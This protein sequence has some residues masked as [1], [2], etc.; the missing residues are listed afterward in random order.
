MTTQY[1]RQAQLLIGAGSSLI[2][3]SQMEMEFQVQAWSMETPKTAMIRVY[4]LKPDTARRVTSEGAQVVLSAGYEGN[5]NT[6][7][8]GQLIQARIGRENGTDTYLDITAAVGDYVYNHGTLNLTVAAGV[9]VIGRLGM[10]ANA[11]G[12][13]LGTV[14][15]PANDAGLPRGRVYFGLARDHL[16][17]ECAS[18][19]A[20][21]CITDEGKLDVIASGSYKPGDIPVINA[22]TG[23]I[24]VPEQTEIGVMVRCLLN[25]NLQQNMV[26]QLD[27]AQ[28]QQ[29]A[30]PIGYFAE[31]D[32]A[33]IP[34]LSANGLYKILYVNHVGQTRG[35]DW[36]TDLI[37]YSKIV[38]PGQLQ[39]LPKVF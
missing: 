20:H 27:N 21:W 22:S 12:L 34:D 9:G 24:G 15:A 6:I 2:D 32:A 14:Q 17:K 26:V 3:L 30:Y 18:I 23:L 29:M 37:C 11:V 7:F 31:K 33:F 16:R 35:N 19:G 36:Y 10:I 39:F 25:P 8:N 5:F 13:T 28:I 1:G 38:N 4:N